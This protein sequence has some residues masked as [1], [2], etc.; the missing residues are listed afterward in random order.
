MQGVAGVT[1]QGL[2]QRD[3]SLEGAIMPDGS[4]HP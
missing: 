4:K 2:E 1:S 3:Y